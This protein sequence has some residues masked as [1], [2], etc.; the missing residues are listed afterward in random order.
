M[1]WQY[2]MHEAQKNQ[3]YD[4][5]LD[6]AQSSELDDISSFSIRLLMDVT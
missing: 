2:C 4:K 6:D 3:L 1:W 5:C